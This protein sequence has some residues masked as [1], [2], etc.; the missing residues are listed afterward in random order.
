MLINADLFRPD[1]SHNAI[2][3]T[4]GRTDTF[5]SYSSERDKRKESAGA[6]INK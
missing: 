6:K 3:Y 1:L 5:W 2:A 4:R